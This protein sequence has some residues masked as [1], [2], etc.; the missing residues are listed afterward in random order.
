[1]NVGIVTA[2][3]GGDEM[4][5]VEIGRSLQE[6]PID[7]NR[8]SVLEANE[9]AVAAGT[10]FVDENL[11][12]SFN[13]ADPES[14]IYERRRA[15]EVLGWCA[16]GKFDVILD[17]HT[18]RYEDSVYAGISVGTSNAAIRVA[19]YLQFKNLLVGNF[20]LPN[21]FSQALTIE[22]PQFSRLTNDEMIKYWRGEIKSLLD[23]KSLD[24]LA[25]NYSGRHDTPV[26]SYQNAIFVGNKD[27]D[28]LLDS[29]CGD[30]GFVSLSDQEAE[31]LGI[32]NVF[33][34]G[35]RIPYVINCGSS[36]LRFGIVGEYVYY[37]GR[38]SQPY[39]RDIARA[40][41]GTEI[42]WAAPQMVGG[43]R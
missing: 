36:Y 37:A 27:P 28:V 8:V 9:L 42:T 23:Y 2:V 17:L 39:W 1:M 26:W 15:V 6:D 40:L 34:G 18:T 16:A 31:L 5:A 12:V 35:H 19:Q 21:H 24:D 33:Q 25:C 11:V 30:G 22:I 32:S 41:N 29:I 7:P 43:T 20:G 3:H 13:H 4:L 38:T 10:R 14:H